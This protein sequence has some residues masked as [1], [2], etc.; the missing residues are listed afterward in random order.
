MSAEFGPERAP[1]DIESPVELQPITEDFTP[2]ADLDVP[3]RIP[4]DTPSAEERLRV[5]KWLFLLVAAGGIAATIAAFVGPEEVWTRVERVVT[6]I[7]T[8]L[9][10]LLA[11]GI[12]W[13]F[14]KHSK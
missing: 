1:D 6:L 14:G 9:L 10:A 11:S 2:S 3:T 13:F 4:R 8:P 7:V 5:L 12:G